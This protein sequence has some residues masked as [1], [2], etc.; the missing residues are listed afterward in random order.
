[1]IIKQFVLTP[2]R[3]NTRV[4]ACGETRSA[5]CIDPGEQSDE[6]EEYIKD[7]DLNLQAIALTHG[8]LDHIGG[9]AALSEAFPGAEVLLHEG[10]EEMYYALPMQPLMLGIEPHQA[11]SAQNS[12]ICG[13]VVRGAGYA[14]EVSAFTTSSAIAA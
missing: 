4:I 11:A 6:L 2:F 13:H 3:Q 1:M 14:V 12:V 8:H 10:D 9:T 5:I 7:S